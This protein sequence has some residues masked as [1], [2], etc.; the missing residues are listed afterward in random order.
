MT[1]PAVG[2]GARK[3]T[4]EHT[5]LAHLTDVELLPDV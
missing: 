2:T 3:S 1:L 5:Q 4:I